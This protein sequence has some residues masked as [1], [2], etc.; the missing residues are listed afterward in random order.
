MP[1]TAS[2]LITYYPTLALNLSQILYRA[3]MEQGPPP[4]YSPPLWPLPTSACGGER[5]EYVR[6]TR[7]WDHTQTTPYEMQRVPIITAGPQEPLVTSSYPPFYTPIPST[8]KTRKFSKRKIPVEPTAQLSAPIK[9]ADESCDLEP[10][11]ELLKNPMFS[12]MRIPELSYPNDP[13]QGPHPKIVGIRR[14]LYEIKDE[15][16]AILVLLETLFE[17]I[18][19]AK[20]SEDADRAVEASQTLGSAIGTSL[21]NDS[22]DWTKAGPGSEG[23]SQNISYSSFANLSPEVLHELANHLR[24]FREDVDVHSRLPTQFR[25]NKKEMLD[26]QLFILIEN[27]EFVKL[28]GILDLLKSML[29]E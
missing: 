20:R 11:T 3:P 25:N 28:L 4:D 15:I 24:K 18:P 9:T 10:D 27:E 5:P 19:K 7:L 22:S 6:P 1:F 2:T 21:T 12:S 13:R 26:Y 17:Q 29:Q 23:K 8:P 16:H 14:E